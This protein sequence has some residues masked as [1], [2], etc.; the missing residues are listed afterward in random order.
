MIIKKVRG[1][2]DI[3]PEEVEKIN[4]VVKTCIETVKTFGFK[5]VILPVLEKIEL[6]Q[7]SVGETT[8]IVEKQMFKIASRTEEQTET[9]V[10][11]PE[12]TAGIVRMFVENNLKDKY[13]LK[14]F[15][16]FGP[17][18]RYERPQKARYREFYQFG[19][20]IFA[21]APPSSDFL[22]IKIANNIFEKLKI[23]VELEINSIGCVNCRKDYIVALKRELEKIKSFLCDV[24]KN[25]IEKNPLRVFDCKSDVEKVKRI[26]EKINIQNFL[27]D[28]CKKN[29]DDLIKLFDEKKIQYKLVPTLV[30]GLD[31]YNGTVFEYKTQLLDAAQ[32]TLCAGGRYDGLISQFEP[33]IK[34]ACGLAFGIDRIT[35]ILTEHKG[36]DEVIKIGIAIVDEKF[37]IAGLNLIDKILENKK[38]VQIIG[39][40][41]EKSLKA[42][43]R[44]FNNENCKYVIII[45]EEMKQDKIVLKNFLYNTQQVVELQNLHKFIV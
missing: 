13:P 31:Y 27:C 4:I 30:R 38:D 2:K 22:L 16:Y 20:E 42:Q 5:E 23:K 43:L 12:G 24:C 19:I 25:R 10:L 34:H 32:N 14:R 44:L 18:F 1:V 11:R 3:L 26:A 8:D 35:E 29:F 15:Y 6:Y 9:I 28:S 17:M 41:T 33:Q 36:V 40:F 21:E 7:H 37:L 39:P 45:G